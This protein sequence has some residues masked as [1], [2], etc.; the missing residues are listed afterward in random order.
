[1]TNQSIYSTTPCEY[2]GSCTSIA[3]C[4]IRGKRIQLVPIDATHLTQELISS[5]YIYSCTGNDLYKYMPSGPFTTKETYST[6]LE[7]W[8]TDPT[9]LMY[10]I[11]SIPTDSTQPIPIGI[12]CYLEIRPSFHVVEIGH[13]WT[14]PQFQSQQIAF[15]ATYLLTRFAI[16]YSHFLPDEFL[17]PDDPCVNGFARVEWKTHHLNVPSQKCALACGFQYEGT[18]KKHMRFKG[19]V[20]DTLWYSILNDNWLETKKSI[21]KR[22][23]ELKPLVLKTDSGSL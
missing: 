17:S 15:E 18:F 20:R 21:E 10:M 12:I 1:M 11:Q 4:I 5:F 23:S 3:P 14:A 9:K 6:Y 2:T 16:E 7:S 8:T 19:M 13:I 22:V